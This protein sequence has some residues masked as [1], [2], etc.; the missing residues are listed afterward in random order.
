MDLR[1]EGWGIVDWMHLSQ[2]RDQWR[3]HVN[4]VMEL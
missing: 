4:T 2:D 3:D 1:L